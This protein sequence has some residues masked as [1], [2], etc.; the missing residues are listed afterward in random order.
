[1]ERILVSIT[2]ELKEKAIEISKELGLSRSALIRMA[3]SN[4]LTDY[5]RKRKNWW[6][7]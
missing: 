7:K 5:D 2:D 3:L 4:Y 6:C 1:M